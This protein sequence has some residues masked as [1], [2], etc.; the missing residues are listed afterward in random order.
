LIFYDPTGTIFRV[1]LVSALAGGAWAVVAACLIYF[2]SVRLAPRIPPSRVWA[3][4]RRKRML[5]GLSVMLTTIATVLL[6][7]ALGRRI[8]LVDIYWMG[9]PE[10]LLWIARLAGACGYLLFLLGV[11][12]AGLLRRRKSAG[13]PH[14]PRP[15]STPPRK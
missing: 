4:W 5:W 12:V 6:A 10:A 9:R 3:D 8:G 13:A 14:A 15:A 1:I 2:G 11:V 7:E